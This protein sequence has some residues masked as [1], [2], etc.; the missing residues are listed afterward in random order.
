LFVH[1]K[2]QGSWYPGYDS[3]QRLGYVSNKRHTLYRCVILL[4]ALMLLMIGPYMQ[5]S[6]EYVE[7]PIVY[8]RQGVFLQLG[9][10]ARG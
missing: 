8:S 4:A 7:N 6:C 3:V 5:S 2:P 10:W 9:G 1:E